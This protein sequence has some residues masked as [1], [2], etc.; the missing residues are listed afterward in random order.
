MMR[1]YGWLTPQ[2]SGAIDVEYSKSPIFTTNGIKDLK[3]AG[4]D[5]RFVLIYASGRTRHWIFVATHEDTEYVLVV[6]AKF[7][8]RV[9][10]TPVSAIEL[11]TAHFPDQGHIT[12]PVAEDLIEKPKSIKLS[13]D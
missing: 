6:H 7:E 11:W 1:S 12:L 10:K 5:F 2:P 8:R 4:A 9:F 13:I 3:D